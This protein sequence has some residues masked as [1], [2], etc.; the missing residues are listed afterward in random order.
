MFLTR[1]PAIPEA[2]ASLMHSPSPS[3]EARIAAVSEAMVTGQL[4]GDD[5]A[6]V[7]LFC[8]ATVHGLAALHFTG[9]FAHDD[10]VFRRVY[11]RAVK[12]L[13]EALRPG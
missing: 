1:R 11:A 3:F 13:L 9:R 4:A 6:E 8:W 7:I 2:P 10:T 12:R 5:P